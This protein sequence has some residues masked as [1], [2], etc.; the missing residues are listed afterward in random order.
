VASAAA[1][2]G[3]FRLSPDR[4]LEA[5][6]NACASPVWLA[7]DY[8]AWHLGRDEARCLQAW[9]VARRLFG[10]G[11]YS[12]SARAAAAVLLSMLARNTGR[13][14]VVARALEERFARQ[15]RRSDA[16][17]YLRGAY[18]CALLTLGRRDL[19]DE[20]RTLVESTAFPAR[21]GLT[22]LVLAGEAAGFDHVLAGDSFDPARMD[23]FLTGRLMARVYA[24]VVPDMP[25]FDV[26]A[27]AAVRA[28]ECRLLRDHYLIHRRA[29]LGRMRR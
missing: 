13:A 16:D 22:A 27:P 1:A 2:V 28:W 20:V 18:A 3:L 7:G 14:E 9:E 11:V 10:P 15:K 12:D 19:A 21:R 6:R 25:A 24:S 23:S 4:A 8:V 17:P 26:E 29:I 5:L